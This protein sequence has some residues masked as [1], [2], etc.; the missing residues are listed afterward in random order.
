MSDW[1]EHIA[2]REEA[3]AE[4]RWLAAERREWANALIERV[5]IDHERYRARSYR[6][7]DQDYFAGHMDAY[8]K[9]LEYLKEYL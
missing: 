4:E 2:N 1:D 9:V 7:P 5:S 8:E 6:D 3:E